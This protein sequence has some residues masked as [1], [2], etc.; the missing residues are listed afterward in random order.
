MT[1]RTKMDFDQVRQLWRADVPFAEMARLLGVSRQAVGK[2]CVRHGLTGRKFASACGHCEKMT[3]SVRVRVYC[4]KKCR[5]L[6]AQYDHCSC[7]RVK[8]RKAATCH[9]CRGASRATIRK[10][11]SAYCRGMTYKQIGAMLGHG[12]MTVWD[13]VNAA[14]IKSRRRG[15]RSKKRSA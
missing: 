14:G 15:T 11:I 10:A 12:T 7:G 8:S 2:F 13:W 1:K 9:E 3:Q 4:S 5:R 6:A